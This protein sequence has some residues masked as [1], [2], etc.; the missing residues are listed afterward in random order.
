MGG[1]PSGTRS[2]GVVAPPDAR[3]DAAAAGP[4]S[5]L[6]P[7]VARVLAF[8]VILVGGACGGVIGAA[9]V[10]VQCVGDCTDP[11]A[12]GALV[13]A[14]TGAAG[15]AVVAVLGLRAMGEWRTIEHGRAADREYEMRAEDGRSP[16]LTYD[17]AGARRAQLEE[18]ERREALEPSTGA[19]EADGPGT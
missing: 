2:L 18:A 13:G 17:P 8:V 12:L 19:G 10:N 11:S 4:A 9:V 14:V 5:A 7:V 1:G 3:P 15:V 16:R 6:P